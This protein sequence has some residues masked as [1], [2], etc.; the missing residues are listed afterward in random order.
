MWTSILLLLKN[1]WVIYGAIA[2]CCVLF[3]GGLW[4]RGS[5]YKGKIADMKAET[6][7]QKVAMYEAFAKQAELHNERLITIEKLGKDTQEK[8]K[9]L[10]L[11]KE[12][13]QNAD[14]Y[15]LANDILSRLRQ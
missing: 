9:G 13:C 1:K 6:E 2:L 14:Y 8:I 5:Y 10:K 15:R 3:I 7:A 11:E 4:L 12:K